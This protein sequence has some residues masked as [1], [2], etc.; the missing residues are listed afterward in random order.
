M[1]GFYNL[2]VNI[3]LTNPVYSDVRTKE[4][5]T[6]G[7]RAARGGENKFIQGFGGKA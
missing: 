1:N 3:I 2:S 5:D 6:G 7:A 4:H